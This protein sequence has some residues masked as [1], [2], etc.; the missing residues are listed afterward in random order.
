MGDTQENGI[1]LKWPKPPPY[2]TYPA[3]DN[4]CMGVREAVVGSYQEK[5]SESGYC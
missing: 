1:T 2:I 3:K 4:R 5:Y